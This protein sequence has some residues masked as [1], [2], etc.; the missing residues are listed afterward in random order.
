MVFDGNDH[1]TMTYTEPKGDY[2]IVEGNMVKINMDGKKAEI[3]YMPFDYTDYGYTQQQ[4]EALTLTQQAEVEARAGKG[5]PNEINIPNINGDPDDNYKEMFI[6][7]R[8][9]NLPR[10]R[11]QRDDYP[12]D[13]M[14]ERTAGH[15][16]GNASKV[17]LEI[18]YGKDNS[19]FQLA[20][21]KVDYIKAPQHIRLTQEQI[22]LTEDTSQILEFPD[23]VCQE[24][25]NELVKL[26]LENAGDPRTSTQPLV[27]QSIAS[28][29]QEQAPTKS[30]K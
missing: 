7:L 19:V 18:R 14:V 28:P 5:K 2:F 27:S 8:D 3:D 1:L 24:I 12:L 6:D 29:A 15:R 17:R 21:I 22:D 30:K 11:K 9:Q 13:D 4:W 16:Y 10:F 26:I 25:I 20:A 23:Y